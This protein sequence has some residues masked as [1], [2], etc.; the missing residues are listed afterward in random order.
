VKLP[1]RVRPLDGIN[2]TPL[3]D[4]FLVLLVIFMIT[5]PVLKGALE[6]A[7][8]QATLG[9]NRV[10][11]GL[12]LELKANGQMSLNGQRLEI[13]QLLPLLREKREEDSL[14]TALIFLAADGRVPYA[15]VVGVLDRLQQGGF[16]DVGLM[17]D[18]PHRPSK[19]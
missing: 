9:A 1:E 5:A 14:S 10:D 8:P 16:Q 7:L 6:V 13:D 19:K 18:P 3:V 17:T 11:T 12:T 2:V 15:E 4:V